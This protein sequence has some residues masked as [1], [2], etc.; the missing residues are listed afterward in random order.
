MDGKS[1]ALKRSKLE[2]IMATATSTTTQVQITDPSLLP[3]HQMCESVYNSSQQVVD[4]SYK[5]WQ[6]VNGKLTAYTEEVRTRGSAL[7][8]NKPG[9]SIP[10]QEEL[11]TEELKL[12]KEFWSFKTTCDQMHWFGLNYQRSIALL[13]PA[14]RLVVDE[15]KL[16]KE[17]PDLYKQVKRSDEICRGYV[18]ELSAAL[19]QVQSLHQKMVT[20]LN[21]DTAWWLQRYCQTVQSGK[22]LSYYTRLVDQV[23]KIVVPKPEDIV[24]P[25][26]TRSSDQEAAQAPLVTAPVAQT[27]S[28]PNSTEMLLTPSLNK[29]QVKAVPAATQEVSQPSPAAPVSGF[30][31]EI[32]VEPVASQPAAAPTVAA[33][34]A[35]PRGFFGAL[36][37][38]GN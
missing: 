34:P 29:E 5:N 38:R 16:S 32:K 23:T 19:A 27:L 11:V 18:K 21:R 10:P 33:A 7:Q 20:T 3:F 30:S 37:S 4:T 25:Q 31:E 22:P 17:N 1:S 6:E 24:I 28:D 13:T 36:F 8:L 2:A 9:D 12:V 15:Q 14:L 26:A 35:A